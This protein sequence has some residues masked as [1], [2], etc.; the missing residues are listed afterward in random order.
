M[1]RT[2]VSVLEATTE[3]V[4]SRRG[5]PHLSEMTEFT[6]RVRETVAA[7][8]Y[9]KIAS[10]GTIAAMAG[11]PRAA[12]GVGYALRSLSSETELPWWRVINRHGEIST[13]ELSGTAH[14][15]RAI[16]ESEG[17]VFNAEGRASWDLFGWD[18]HP[19]DRSDC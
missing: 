6:K 14:V 16:L 12:R 3:I 18:P 17:V 11:N 8:P 15:Q 13:S 19:D 2:T 1:S 10:Y 4:V 7:I 5:E 9:G